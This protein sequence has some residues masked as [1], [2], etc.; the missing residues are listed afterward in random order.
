[1]TSGR[2][3]APKFGLVLRAGDEGVNS[4]E[5]RRPLAFSFF[6]GCESVVVMTE[7][8]TNLALI[9]LTAYLLVVAVVTLTA[10]TR[11]ASSAQEGKAEVAVAVAAGAVV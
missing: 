5:R 7:E 9:V 2:H 4:H 6:I 11:P 8:T 10:R 1:M 3:K